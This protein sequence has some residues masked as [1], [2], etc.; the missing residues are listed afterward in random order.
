MKYAMKSPSRSP[1]FSWGT[2][3]GHVGLLG[4]EHSRKKQSRRFLKC[5]EEKFLRQLVSKAERE[6]GPVGPV[7]QEERRAGG[8]WKSWRA[9]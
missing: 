1:S 3:T 9:S 7:V 8:W 4:I 2:S 5:V 6:G